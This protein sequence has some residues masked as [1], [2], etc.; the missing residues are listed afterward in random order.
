LNDS[1]C[2]YQKCRLQSIAGNYGAIAAHHRDSP[3]QDTG[4]SF[5]GCSIRG[6]GNVYLGRAWGDYSRVIYSNCNM[7][8]I[9]K[10]EGWSEWN[11]PERRKYV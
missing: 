5:V 1:V 8:D 7:D 4:F 10:P 11:H 9:I 6:T 3:L 2:T